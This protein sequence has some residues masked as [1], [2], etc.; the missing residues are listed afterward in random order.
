MN[1]RRAVFV[2]SPELSI[3]LAEYCPVHGKQD[4]QLVQDLLNMVHYTV[5]PSSVPVTWVAFFVQHIET[6][7][8]ARPVPIDQFLSFDWKFTLHFF[9]SVDVYIRWF[10]NYHE[11]VVN[12]T[13]ANPPHYVVSPHSIG[14]PHIHTLTLSVFGEYNACCYWKESIFRHTKP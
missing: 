6:R 5:N 3:F 4:S 12:D 10:A 7:F 11:Y 8:L 2:F 9:Q 14:P 13:Y 1:F